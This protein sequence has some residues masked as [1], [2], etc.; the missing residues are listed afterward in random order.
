M[1]STRA[2]AVG[3]VL[4]L[5]ACARTGNAPQ[6][7][8]TG[9]PSP[10]AQPAPPKPVAVDATRLLG[11]D[12]DPGN[13]MSYG[14]TYGEQRFSPLRDIT[15]TNVGQLKLAWHFDLDA[16]HR[17]QES[18]PIVVDGIMY[19]TSAW[20][21]V[22]ALD[23]RSGRA[24][25]TYDPLVPGRFG[26]NAC[27]D[28]VN[29]GVA[30]WGGKV[31]VGTIDGRLVA[32]DSVTGKP[33]WQTQTADAAKRYTITGAPRVI[34]GKVLI[35]NAGA[36]LGVRGYVSAYDAD[37]GKLAW[38]FYTVPG[39]PQAPADGAASDAPL[40]K[41]AQRTWK[42]QWW[43]LGGGG[44]VWDSMAYDP[45]LDLL[46]IGTDNGTPWNQQLRSPGGGDNLFISSIIAL[47]PDSGEY[48]WHYQETPG[49]SWDYSS[50][51][52]IVLADLMIDGRARQ[53]ILHAPKSGFFYVID[54][55]SGKLI[56]AKPFAAVNWAKRIDLKTGRPIENPQARFGTTGKPW[57][58]MPGPSGAHNWQPMSYS[59]LT[60]LVYVP[61]TEM[62]FAYVPDH[63]FV[64][65]PTLGWNTGVDFDAGSLPQDPKV[66]TQ[67]K[68]SLT[69]HLLAWDPVAQREVWRA[70]YP[71]PLNGGLL[72]TAGNLVFQ[73]TAHAELVA[74]QADNGKRLWAA[75]TEAAVVAPPVTYAVDGTQY[76]AV[77][78]GFGGAFA[79]AA[80][81]LARDKHVT[82]ENSPHVLVFSLTGTDR[83][84]AAGGAPLA[85][86]APPPDTATAA[87]VAAGKTTYHRY[88]GTC[89][90]DSAVSGAV[91]PDLRLSA[92]LANDSVWQ[93]IVRDGARESRGM[94]AF[95]KVL[96]AQQIAG[97]R[98]YVIHRA[99][100]QPATPPAGA[101]P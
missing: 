56:S 49:E 35:G 34:K 79:L 84:P 75:P 8:T 39:D 92:A 13:W 89:H 76:V 73:G 37:S 16:V 22:F 29:R 87:E 50:T 12:N 21:K 10:Q 70:Q 82:A 61:V 45:Q 77:E 14:R 66:K 38:R 65:N 32:L 1:I 24:L 58:A 69:G 83:M 5:A 63:P 26:V 15:A 85:A 64:E 20:S 42:G 95:G 19:V 2:L 18:T 57:L 96:S 4:L 59:P 33:V 51:Q 98:A 71:D 36:E 78:T 88:C 91:L 23:A 67:I 48:V 68:S 46:Y 94:V 60:H 7:P 99:H 25:W 55:A 52:H 72:S 81:E 41:I 74:Y 31:F 90:G 30:V 11:A 86:A 6:P 53:V 17:G 97:A 80:G 3:A 9:A 100:E 44:T 101:A 62:S 47:R 40:K 27:C 28:V 43:K 54:R 93:S